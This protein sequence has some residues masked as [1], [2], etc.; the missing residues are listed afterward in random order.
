MT[1]FIKL[2]KIVLIS[3]LILGIFGIAAIGVAYYKVRPDLPDVTAL[4]DVQLQVPLKVYT[5]AGEL[6]AEFGEKKRVLLTYEQL[7]QTVVNAFVAAEDA[8]FFSHL[9][10]DPRGL[11]RALFKLVMTGQR[12]QGGS[13]ITMQ[14]ARNFYLSRDKTYLRKLYEIFLALRIEQDLSKS[15]ILALYLNKIYLGQRAYGIGA[16]AQ[17][18]YGKPLADLSLAQV[19]MLAGLPKAPSRYN[20]LVNPRRAVV[21]RNYVLGQMLALEMISQTDYAQAIAAPVSAQRYTP[22]VVVEAPYVAE[23]VRAKMVEQYGDAAYTGGY[24]VYT[25]LQG[26]AQTAANRALRKS[27]DDYS[28]RHGYR[29]PKAQYDISVDNEQLDNL[30]AR[31]PVVGKQLPG[32]VTAVSR[33][34]AI[35][36][37]GPAQT[38]TLPWEGLRWARKYINVNKQ[39]PAPKRASDV[40]QP[41]DLVRVRQ[42][43]TAAGEATWQLSQVPKLLGALVSLQPA[44][45]A[46]LALIGGYDYYTQQFNSATQAW[47]QPG[48]GLKAFVY[49]AALEK[50]YTPASIIHDAPVVFQDRGLE[51]TWRPEN[52]SGRVHGPT[53]LRTAL[54]YSRNLISIRLLRDIG[55]KYTVQYL[56]RFGFVPDKLAHN[57]SLALGNASVTPLQMATGYAVL[58]NGGYRVTPYFIERITQHGDTLY[59]A[60]P[61]R[62]CARCAQRAPR[63]I[64]AQNRYLMYSMLQDV[65]RQGTAKAARTL[66]RTDIAG[67]TGTTNDQR[68]AWFNGFNESFVTSVWTGFDNNQKLG[69]GEF[70]GKVAL[71]AW[72][73]YMAAVLKDTDNR[74]PKMPAGIIRVR[75]DPETGLKAPEGMEKTVSE[76]FRVKNVPKALATTTVDGLA[77]TDEL[78]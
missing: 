53:R 50:G 9:G 78:F 27:L 28:Q 72:M 7:P 41:G 45:G 18:Y 31:H 16:A 24:A 3:L 12:Q 15:E 19:A 32:I 25:T 38:I 44:D 66:K 56:Q 30:L 33:R 55:I 62:N 58:A 76:V 52:E 57:L 39:G 48:S 8:Y 68:D 43:Q 11:A 71:P 17:A 60:S 73:D 23:M 13:T 4:N 21:R 74:P 37:L 1:W 36:Y 20:P 34:T 61:L 2:S 67:K 49:S 75:I 46:I 14:V 54:T 47:R 40:L 63:A 59:Q 5:Q 69:N 10:V 65:V 6:I 22:P 51:D 70:G 64:S 77:P 29:G 42:I 26:A 35:V